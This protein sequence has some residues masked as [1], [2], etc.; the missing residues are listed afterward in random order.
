M[1]YS[2]TV[3]WAS[4]V[5]PSAL[6]RAF[7]AS[8]ARPAAAGIA[9]VPG[10]FV[11]PARILVE[12]LDQPRRGIRIDVIDERLLGDVDLIARD[13]GRDG[14]HD[15]E[16]F[17]IAFEVVGHRQHRAIAVAHEDDLGRLIEDRRVGTGDV[18]AAERAERLSEGPETRGEG[19]EEQET[20]H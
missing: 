9:M 3:Y 5:T 2:P 6:A 1:S 19:N 12:V 4:I 20:A 15:G 11:D 16:L 8:T 10:H 14:N 13:E 7:T 18:E 17:R